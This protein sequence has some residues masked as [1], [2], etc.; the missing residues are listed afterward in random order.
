MAGA[1][2]RSRSVGAQSPATMGDEGDQSGRVRPE[3]DRSGQVANPQ[4]RPAQTLQEQKASVQVG[5]I[6]TLRPPI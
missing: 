5:S 6:R 2:P 1:V 3:P 4:P